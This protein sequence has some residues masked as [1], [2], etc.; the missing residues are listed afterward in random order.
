MRRYDA[1]L[2]D[3]DGTLLDTEVLH[4]GAWLE[5]AEQAGIEPPREWIDGIVSRHDAH[6][7]DELV[8]IF[9]QLAERDILEEKQRRFR[10][11]ARTR[12]AA[13]V[14]PGVEEALERLKA[15]GVKLAV[16]TNSVMENTVFSLKT[17]GLDRC[18]DVLVALDMVARAKPEPDIYLEAM[19]R[20]GA[21]PERS[22]VVEDS[23]AGLA[24]GNA[25]GCTTLGVT[26]TLAASALRD[27]DQVFDS[28]AAA[29]DWVLKRNEI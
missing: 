24:A 27:A 4:V 18:F 9:P 26:N 3:L 1:V 11:L 20:L 7:R 29:L 17:A 22:C 16:G 28:S 10:E 21:A 23:A 25:A 6:A 8:R 13:L 14:F 19:R 5:L 15:A 12:G 2:C